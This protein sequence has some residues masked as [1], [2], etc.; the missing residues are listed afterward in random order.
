M[1]KTFWIGLA[2]LI[3]IV[4][5]V[6][7]WRFF[8]A[9]GSRTKPGAI[10]TIPGTANLPAAKAEPLRIA[11]IGGYSL[12]TVDLGDGPVPL[13]RIP[14]DTWGGYAAL[15][16]AN[17]GAAPS[18]T[19]VFYSTYKFAVELVREESAQA[20]MDGFAAGRYPVIWSS[21][22][23]LP[24]LYDSL[25]SDKRVVPQVIGLF[26]WSVGG[27]GILVRDF[28]H[29]PQDLKGATIL[30][31]SPAPYSFF[32]LWYLA[33]L[34]IN[35]Q[36]VKIVHVPDGPKALETF[37]KNAGIAA[38]VTWTPF[39]TDAVREGN[40]GYVPGTRLLITSKDANQ[41]IADVFV[42]RNDFSREKPEIAKGLVAGIFRGYDL[43]SSDSNTAYA[44]M[45]SFYKLKGGASEAKGM[46]D[47]VHLASYP[48]AKMFFDP[49]NPIGAS[50]L[51]FLSQE[52]YKLLGVLPKDVSYESERV[53]Y[54][55]GIEA[56]GASG[57]FASQKNT[58]QN[59][60]NRGAAL[61][62]NDLENQHTVLSNDIQLYF[63]AQ[64]LDFDPKSTI[65]EI[66]ENM[67]LLGKVAEQTK[68]LGT[69]VVKLVGHLDTTKVADF[70]A[71]GPQAFVEASAQAKLISK[72]RAEFVKSVLVSHFGVDPERV[73]TEGRGWDSP[74][75]EKDPD[76]NRRVEVQFLSFE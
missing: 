44:A 54:A 11:G 10:A 21:M 5:A 18:K 38:W 61:D 30:T 29:K 35:P 48:E 34:D 25:R 73:V 42:A 69:T 63:A 22:D 26:D 62:I 55:A 71:K 27:D 36:D 60:F 39:L 1:K 14:L 9:S 24:L 47:E 31:S 52:Y 72:R 32:L 68:F 45:A 19:S 76:R 16:A 33:Q 51:F 2:L 56:A 41:L 65:P 8:T 46:L 4:G 7:G 37:K 23:S 43:L 57:A 17:G 6:V 58:I 75:D 40:Q 53:I 12:S 3:L 66:K 59:S 13:L 67:R 28:V 20:Q 74:V 49:T 50:K 70:K 64:K 15:F